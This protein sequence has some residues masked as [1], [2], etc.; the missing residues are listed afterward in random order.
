MKNAF[1][2]GWI[3]SLALIFSHCTSDDTLDDLDQIDD[4]IDDPKPPQNLLDDRALP[5]ATIHPTDNP[6][7]NQKIE[8]G[9]LLFF[10]PILSGEKDVACAT[11]H[12]P[13]FGFAD[14][15]DLSIGVGGI[16]LGPN[17]VDGTNREIPV[18]KRNAPTIINTA[19]N[20]IEENG[21]VIPAAAPMFWD[22]RD[23]SLESQAL[24]PPKSFEEMRGHAFSEAETLDS[25]VARINALVAYRNRFQ[26]AFGN[27]NGVTSENI[28]KAIAAY[29][30]TIIANNSAFDR[31]AR[32]DENALN[33][34]Q[35]RGMARFQQVGCADCHSGPMF[36]DFELHVLGVPD[37]NQ[38]DESDSG[39]NGT[40]AF[41]TPTL[42]NLNMTG[43]YFHSGV[44]GNLGDVLNFYRRIQGNNNGPGNGPGNLNLNPNV[45]RNQLDD[46]I[47][48]LQ[49]NGNDVQDIIAFLGALNDNNFDRTIP[50]EVPSGLR[51][52]GNID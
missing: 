2:F 19:F 41:R 42:R 5:L 34:Q 40:Y 3:L 23:I 51:V 12:H 1:I 7:N 25:I 38:L 29:E 24:G 10:D 8:L 35:S 9:R 17:R 13:Q 44:A 22:N 46:E 20:G 26:Q 18:V 47:R 15:R 30:R 52:G 45:N 11:C 32:G 31:Y 6:A 49:L 50:S 16:G 36:S 28:G 39:A 43:P 14:G 37:N 21:E 4:V 33:Q 27:N 48:N